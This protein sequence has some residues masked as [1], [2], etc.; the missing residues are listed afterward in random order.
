M[1]ARALRLLLF[2]LP[3]YAT[4]E[5]SRR[6]LQAQAIISLPTAILLLISPLNATLS[7]LFI[8]GPK[9]FQLGF[10]GAPMS[11]VISFNLMG[12]SS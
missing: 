3:G 7:Y 11:T 6:W 12:F 2:A 8:C 5:I 9:P 1:A 10:M 4:F